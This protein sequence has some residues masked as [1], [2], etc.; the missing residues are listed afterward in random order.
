MTLIKVCGITT[1]ED[2]TMVAE[3][4]VDWIG[5]NFWSESKRHVD[6]MRARLIVAQARRVNPEIKCVGLF[7]N[8]SAR[9]IDNAVE[10]GALDYVQLH[11]D[12]SPV[13]AKRFGDRCIKA[14]ALAEEADLERMASYSCGWLLADTPTPGRGGSGLVGDWE[15][16]ARAAAQH[17]NLWLAG[18]LRPDNVA[19]AIAAVKPFGVDV[20]S[21]VEDRPGVKNADKVRAFVEAVRGVV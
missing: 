13:F 1:P 20:A 8:H 11:G 5:L 7:V 10:A 18:G 12:E 6:R 3:A 17:P 4:G 9:E 16:A 15:L 14:V 21:G 2:A 19:A